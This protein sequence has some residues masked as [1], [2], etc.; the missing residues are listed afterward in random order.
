MIEKSFPSY[1]QK[2]ATKIAGFLQ[3]NAPKG[4]KTIG[5]EAVCLKGEF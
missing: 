1:L 3:Q 4:F 5:A 2:E